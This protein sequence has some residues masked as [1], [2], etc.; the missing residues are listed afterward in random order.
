MRSSQSEQ[1]TLCDAINPPTQGCKL[2]ALLSTISTSSGTHQVQRT[3][4][5][6]RGWRWY[7]PA[8]S[9]TFSFLLTFFCNGSLVTVLLIEVH[10]WV[11]S[12]TC[13]SWY[14]LLSL[15]RS[16]TDGLYWEVH[17]QQA[18]WDFRDWPE[19]CT[20][21][22]WRRKPECCADTRASQTYDGNCSMPKLYNW[23]RQLW[24]K[25]GVGG[26]VGG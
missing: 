8:W 19:S 3:Q 4:E 20:G 7:L 11:S 24:P 22:G 12:V 9:Q 15:S 23:H 21:R 17:Y 6:Q 26:W 5:W 14:Q 18:T 2:L 10:W 13:L 25:R 16:Q 1:E